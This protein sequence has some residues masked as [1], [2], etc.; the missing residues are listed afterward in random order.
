MFNILLGCSTALSHAA[1][2][3]ENSLYKPASMNFTASSSLN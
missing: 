3:K 2:M 1:S